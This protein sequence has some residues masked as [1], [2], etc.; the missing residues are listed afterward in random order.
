MSGLALAVLLSSLAG[1]LHCAGMCGGLAAVAAGG[2]GTG[3]RAAAIAAYNGGRLLAY[4][5]LGALAGAAGRALDLGGALVGVQRLATAAA[6]ALVVGWGALALAQSLGARLPRHRRPGRAE[7][8]VA[9]AL[10]RAGGGSRARRAATVGVLTGLLPC[11]WLWA[12][13]VAAAGTGTWGGGAGLMAVFWL[14]TLPVMA[15][16]GAGALALLGPLRRHAPAVSAL[17]LVAMGLFALVGRAP[18]PPPGPGAVEEASRTLVDPA[19][20]HAHR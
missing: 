17:A 12:F 5:A 1:S 4:V 20:H 8:L 14:G 3:G 13:V 11:G 18:A 19:G 9:A 15:G 16:L 6:G 2:E 10:R 7:A